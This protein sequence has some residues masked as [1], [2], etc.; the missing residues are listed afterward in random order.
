[1]NPAKNK[2]ECISKVILDKNNLAIKSQI[3]LNQW[4][5]PKRSYRLV[6]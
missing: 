3:N 4:K 6:C 2:I 5:K 1:M